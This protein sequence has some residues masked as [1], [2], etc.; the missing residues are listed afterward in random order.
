MFLLPEPL[1]SALRR[2]GAILTSLAEG[3]SPCLHTSVPRTGSCLCAF[4]TN[5]SWLSAGLGSW[6]SDT[7]A[8]PPCG[9]AKTGWLTETDT[10]AGRCLQNQGRE[11]QAKEWPLLV[12]GKTLINIQ[13][14]LVP[15]GQTGVQLRTAERCGLAALVRA[16]QFGK[17]GNAGQRQRQR[18]RVRTKRHSPL[19]WRTGSQI[20]AMKSALVR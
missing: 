16:S 10:C 19:R 3:R 1:I 18:F 9:S 2:L 15:V 5:A 6:K 7:C 14:F 11:S 20:S 4:V 17:R 8:T 13:D 12:D